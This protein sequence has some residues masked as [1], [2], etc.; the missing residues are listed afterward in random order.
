MSR[1]TP[2]L[3]ESA[4]RTMP[5]LFFSTAVTYTSHLSHALGTE[6]GEAVAEERRDE[7]RR[8]RTPIRRPHAPVGALRRGAACR[9]LAASGEAS[10]RARAARA[11]VQ[12]VRARGEA[13]AMAVC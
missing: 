13:A 1:E 4:S 5:P 7:R 10:A 6:E 11:R 12:R 2:C 8:V 3:L 9:Y